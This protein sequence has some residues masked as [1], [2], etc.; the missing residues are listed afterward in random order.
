MLVKGMSR[1]LFR[2]IRV[3][4]SNRIAIA[5]VK[6]IIE[7]AIIRAEVGNDAWNR[8]VLARVCNIS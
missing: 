2:Q 5:F 8:I 3:I 4:V 1:W 6:S 7:L